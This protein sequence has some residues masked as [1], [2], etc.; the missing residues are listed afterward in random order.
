LRV[1]GRTL[2]ANRPGVFAGGDLVTGPN[3][4]V[5]A[6][7]AGRKAANVI[8]RYLRGQELVEPPKRKLPSVFVEPADLSDEELEDVARIEPPTL[9]AKSRKQ[10]CAE[11]EMAFSAEQAAREARRCLRCDL[12]FTRPAQNGQAEC[13]AVEEKSA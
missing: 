3:T 12:E 9:S 7:A 8:D 13:V 5:D 10:S 1:D 2:A 11:V 4:V 6:I